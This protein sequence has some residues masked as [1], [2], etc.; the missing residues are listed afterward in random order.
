MERSN[1]DCYLYVDEMITR[2][3]F[4][5]E[6]TLFVHDGIVGTVRLS[7]QKTKTEINEYIKAK[8]RKA[9]QKPKRVLVVSRPAEVATNG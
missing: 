8:H 2:E 3:K 1:D 6:V 7:E 5:G 9:D 4:H